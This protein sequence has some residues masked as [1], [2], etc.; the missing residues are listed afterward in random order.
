MLLL[1][2]KER[3]GFK[4]PS[5]GSPAVGLRGRLRPR[6]QNLGHMQVNEGNPHRMPALVRVPSERGVA[7]EA[8]FVLQL[9]ISQRPNAQDSVLV[10]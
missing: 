10:L 3:R 2:S 1:S 8:T 9:Q 6:V 5:L 4:A 7:A